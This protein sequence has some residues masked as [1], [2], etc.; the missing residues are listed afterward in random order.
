MS[1]EPSALIVPRRLVLELAR[2]A[3]SADDTVDLSF[4]T[5]HF[6][7]SGPTFVFT[8]VLIDGRFPDYER[9]VPQGVTTWSELI[10]ALAEVLLR[11]LILS[12]EQ[13][14]GVRL[15]LTQ[16]QIDVMANNVARRSPRVAGCGVCWSRWVRNRI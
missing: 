12:S 16:G 6:R 4:S 11:A 15:R 5:S 2:L 9:V 14:R 8:S 13:Y 7:V 1:S 3:S 10:V